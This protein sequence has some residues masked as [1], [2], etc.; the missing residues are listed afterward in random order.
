MMAVPIATEFGS[1]TD[2]VLL[3]READQFDGGVISWMFWHYGER[4]IAPGVPASIGNVTSLPVLQ[5][6]VR[7]YPLALSGTPVSLAYERD[8]KTMDLRYSTLGPSGR[9][10][11]ASLASVVVVPK[12][13]YPAGYRV[14]VTGAEVTSR[15]GADRLTLRNDRRAGE[16]V[17]R[18]VPA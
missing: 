2:D 14:E 13:A 10:Y 12:L 8:T 17:V 6:L 11:P 1:T 3:D 18:I 4:I 5:A 16:V 15:P 9:R 7:P